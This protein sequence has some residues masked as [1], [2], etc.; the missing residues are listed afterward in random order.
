MQ[1]VYVLRNEQGK[2]YYGC[3]QNL[4]KRVEEHNYGEN[5]STQKHKWNVI[6]YEAYRSEEDAF[7]REKQLKQQG[8]ALGQLKRRIKRSLNKS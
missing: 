3:T 8:Q 4:R 6:Y 7:E 1:Y 2:L 5:S